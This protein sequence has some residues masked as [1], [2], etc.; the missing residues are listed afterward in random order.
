MLRR[1]EEKREH[2]GERRED[3]RESQRHEA[4]MISMMTIMASAQGLSISSGEMAKR[5]RKK[6]KTTKD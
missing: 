1:R 2:Q 4:M 6:S 3:R 5:K